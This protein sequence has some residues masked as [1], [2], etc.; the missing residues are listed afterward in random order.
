MS[1]IRTIGHTIF[2]TLPVAGA[3]ATLLL[4]ENLARVEIIIQN[5]SSGAILVSIKSN[6]APEVQNAILVGAGMIY[7]APPVDPKYA[8]SF[9]A[10]LPV[11]GIIF[12]AE[13]IESNT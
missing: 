3:I 10:T 13:N 7:A 5:R 9:S 4:P 1:V 6:S 11:G 2:N 8:V 12:V